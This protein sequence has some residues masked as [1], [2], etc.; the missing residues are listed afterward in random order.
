MSRFEPWP[1]RPLEIEVDNVRD[2]I[3]I[4]G[5]R[6][7]GEVFRGMAWLPV[8]AVLKIVQRED[9]VVAMHWVGKNDVVEQARLELDHEMF[10]E[11][12][13]AEKKRLANRR[14]TWQRV[15]KALLNIVN[16]RTK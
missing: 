6:Y 15:R 2:E 16:W 8:G 4:E 12:V 3:S 7:A 9:G 13:E 14:H 11:A 5:I 1:A 10:R